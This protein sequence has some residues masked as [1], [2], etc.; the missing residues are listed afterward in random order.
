MTAGVPSDELGDL[1]RI[2]NLKRPHWHHDFSALAPCRDSGCQSRS[3]RGP[4]MIFNFGIM[5]VLR[6]GEPQPT[7]RVRLSLPVSSQYVSDSA[8][9]PAAAGGPACQCP[10]APSRAGPPVT[11]TYRH[12]SAIMMM[13]PSRIIW[14]PHS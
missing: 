9:G 14:N 12:D 2:R 11:V 10:G 8:A 13:T 6:P 7:W 3:G 4:V 1:T 5:P